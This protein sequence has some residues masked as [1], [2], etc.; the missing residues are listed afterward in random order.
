METLKA[1]IKKDVRKQRAAALKQDL[2][3]YEKIV[4]SIGFT[5]IELL[6]VIAIISILASFLLPTLRTAREKSRQ[7]VCMNNLRQLGM[8]FLMYA[9]DTDGFLP[10]E[11][12]TGL[13]GWDTIIESYIPYDYSNRNLHKCPSADKTTNPIISYGMPM[14]W[15]RAIYGYT[16]LDSFS[17]ST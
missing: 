4:S 3:K 13:G 6:V 12:K 2:R 9:S 17:D 8:A 14:Y 7:S 5:L 11:Y 1:D 16:R 15:S 10:L